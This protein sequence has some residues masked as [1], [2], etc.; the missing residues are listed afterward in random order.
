M[1]IYV[2]FI[3][4]IIKSR[5]V[6]WDEQLPHGYSNAQD[7]N[8]V[9]DQVI[10]RPSSTTEPTNEENLTE[11]MESQK[12]PQKPDDPGHYVRERIKHGCEGYLHRPGNDPGERTNST[13]CMM[14]GQLTT[15]FEESDCAYLAQ[16]TPLE[17]ALSSP[18]EDTWKIV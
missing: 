6:T 17:I 12:E 18:D 10:I 8:E 7:E 2:R 11:N 15:M 13:Y 1:Y 3:Q 9:K 4:A 5:D 16:S 14:L